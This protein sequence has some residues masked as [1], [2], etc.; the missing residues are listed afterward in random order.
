[1]RRFTLQLCVAQQHSNLSPIGQ[2]RIMG[3]YLPVTG[4]RSFI[5]SRFHG[6]ASSGYGLRSYIM[7]RVLRTKQAYARRQQRAISEHPNGHTSRAKR[8]QTQVP[9]A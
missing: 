7:E 5:P 3:C 1:M 4:R 8:W 6:R 2:M 9:S